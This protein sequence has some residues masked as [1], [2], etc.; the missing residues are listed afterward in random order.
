M[1]DPE[2]RK[3]A[4]RL[5]FD[6]VTLSPDGIGVG[7]GTLQ[8]VLRTG[9]IG[10]LPVPG[11]G[12]G[13]TALDMALG[14]VTPAS[15]QVRVFG[16]SWHR[17]SVPEA[18]AW[19]RRVGWIS[20]NPNWLSNLD[21]DENILL[22]SRYYGDGSEAALQARMEELAERFGLDEI[23]RGR[24]PF[25]DTTARRLYGW[26]RA[27]MTRPGVVIVGAGAA[28]DVGQAQMLGR[29][30]TSGP[31]R[32]Q[33]LLWIVSPEEVETVRRIVASSQVFTWDP[34]DSTD[35]D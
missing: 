4:E 30:L 16:R 13:T 31:E 3:P 21:L 7:F 17:M 27:L 11:P 9:D 18:C 6:N 20:P 32:P 15:G 19:R 23:P 12:V 34:G 24:V 8:G 25:T 35:H 33:A 5:A 22:V 28:N 29:V 1:S 26:I 10:L 14:L 2:T